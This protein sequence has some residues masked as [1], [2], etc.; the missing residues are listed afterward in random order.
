MWHRS[1]S[2]ETGVGSTAEANVYF[3]TTYRSI[4]LKKKKNP[5]VLLLF[6]YCIFNEFIPYLLSIAFH[7]FFH[8]NFSQFSVIFL[9]LFPIH[10]S[11][12]SRC[13][14]GVQQVCSGPS[15]S[16]LTKHMLFCRSVLDQRHPQ[17]HAS[18]GS[19]WPLVPQTK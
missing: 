16:L 15:I 11:L 12:C 6:L 19:L 2:R 17:G 5:S 9:L 7:S 4:I 10:Q 8:S 14:A 3:L 13:T 18:Q 1:G